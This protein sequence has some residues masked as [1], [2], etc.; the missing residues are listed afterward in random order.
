MSM[1]RFSL[2]LTDAPLFPI[3]DKSGGE[4][5]A[6]RGLAYYATIVCLT[7]DPGFTFI[8]K[9][10]NFVLF[11]TFVVKFTFSSLVATMPRWVSVVNT[12]SQETQ[13]HLI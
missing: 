12:T 6:E 1:M 4:K 13:K 5:E 9:L 10:L 11:V 8:F 2:S 7:C 3:I